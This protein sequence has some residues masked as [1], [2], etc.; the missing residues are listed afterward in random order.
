MN[1]EN[2]EEWNGKSVGQISWARYTTSFQISMQASE[3][4]ELTWLG[5]QR[6]RIDITL[7]R[8]DKDSSDELHQELEL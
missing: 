3:E 5:K 8:S 6:R 4:A 1:L 7:N 2:S